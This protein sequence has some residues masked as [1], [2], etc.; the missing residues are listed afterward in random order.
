MVDDDVNYMYLI[1]KALLNC[2]PPCNLNMVS[3]EVDLFNWLEINKRPTVILIDI[4]MPFVDGFD[5]LKSLKTIDR[6]KAIPVVMLSI[7]NEKSDIEKS[8]H[9]GANGYMVKPMQFDHL[10]ER[11][12]SFNN[13]W[14]DVVQTPSSFKFWSDENATLY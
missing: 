10:K 13:Y 2:Q 11:M 9:T 12:D 8:Y 6:Y 1:E 4:N 14:F 5:I 7:S 3:N